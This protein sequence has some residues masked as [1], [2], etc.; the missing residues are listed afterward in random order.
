M[1]RLAA[2]SNN[3]DDFQ[4]PESL[5]L[6]RRPIGPSKELLERLQQDIQKL[7]GRLTKHERTSTTMSFDTW[8]S[9]Q[10]LEKVKY[11][12]GLLL[13]WKKGADY[14][15]EGLKD[16]VIS[17]EKAK[18]EAD[19]KW[20]NLQRKLQQL[21]QLHAELS[22]AQNN[23]LKEQN[24]NRQANLEF[25][26]NCDEFR[27]LFDGESAS[28]AAIWND[29]KRLIEDI[30]QDIATIKVLI[31]E[32]KAKNA[33]V[34]FDVKTI[35]Q[36]A[37]EAAEKLEIQEREFKQIKKQIEQ[38]QLDFEIL[39]TLASSDARTGSAGKE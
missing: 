20:V 23:F 8:K 17:L 14:K 18:T 27:E 4:A 25:A 10:D 21:D 34:I 11:E 26:K 15:L 6:G 28:N 12:A 30:F 39:E 24:Y 31:E 19:V 2:S 38:M 33:S 1:P 37:S 22:V 35:S 5:T 36:I 3:L 32:Q 7:S 29:H 16:T 13:E 9:Q